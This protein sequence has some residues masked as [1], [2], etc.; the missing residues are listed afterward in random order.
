L[1][2]QATGLPYSGTYGFVATDMYW[3]ITHMVAPKEQALQCTDCHGG[4]GRMDWRALGYEGDPAFSE[5]RRQTT[6]DSARDAGG[7]E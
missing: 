5:G 7:R 1:G 4:A 6:M 3:P 2:S